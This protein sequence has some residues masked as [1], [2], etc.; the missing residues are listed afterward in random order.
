MAFDGYREVLRLPG[1]GRV[2]TSVTI[3]RLAYGIIPFAV[4]V[5][6]ARAHGFAAAGVA[7]AVLMLAIAVPAPTRGRLV[8]QHGPKMLIL[9]AGLSVVLLTT[10]ASL[11]DHTP[12]IVGV[13][14]I[15][16]GGAVAPPLSGSA[17]T[18]WSRL[19]PD[20][21][22]LQQMH[23]A[24]SIIEELTFVVAPL[25]TTG[26]L[27]L[28]PAPWCIVAGAGLLIPAVLGL[29]AWGKVGRSGTGEPASVVKTQTDRTRGTLLLQAI[30]QGIILPIIA[31]GVVGGSLAV[32]LPAGA[33]HGGDIASA[34]YSFAVF[35][36]G[37]VVGALLHGR[38][39]WQYSLRTQY[40][41]ATLVLTAGALA[42]IPAITTAF[43]IPAV[44]IAGL[45]MS[46]MYIIGYL[47]VDERIDT[48][49]HTEANTWIG[50]GYN[51]GSAAGSVVVGALIAH[52]SVTVATTVCAAAAFMGAASVLRLPKA[53]PAGVP[54]AVPDDVSSGISTT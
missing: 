46:P 41:L 50:S 42:L 7:S 40:F 39:K 30:G 14:L 5:A 22:Q 2:L 45:A 27:H 15:G 6:S 51:L 44:F 35:S 26:L 54:E 11:L 1:V 25:V 33:A 13:V 47:L 49:R 28:L 53:V 19:V 38:R 37:G 43:A 52:I 17:R 29:A 31:L 23:G 16:L 20:K 18:S 3:G 8:D 36:A 9:F 21:E 32:L 24:D 48:A 4:V 12:W 34:G 10:A